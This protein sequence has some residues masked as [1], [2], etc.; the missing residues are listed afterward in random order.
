MNDKLKNK[1]LGK[2]I[3]ALIQTH[4]KTQK[5]NLF[6]NISQIIPNKNNP[7]ENF[8]KE[9]MEQL[10]ESIYQHGILQPITVRDIGKEQYELIS[11][12]RRFE[13][14]KQLSN[15]YEDI[16]PSDASFIAP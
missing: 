11:G 9:E 8:N 15:E 1:E 3:E 13:A 4:S 14:V 6:I 5:S 10:K 2:G 7:R 12:G 16:N